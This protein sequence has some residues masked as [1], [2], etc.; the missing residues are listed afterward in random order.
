MYDYPS[1]RLFQNRGP[2]ESGRI[3]EIRD[4]RHDSPAAKGFG[5]GDPDLVFLVL[6]LSFATSNAN[7]HIGTL[8]GGIGG[9]GARVA[10]AADLAHRIRILARST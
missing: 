8:K 7:S 5:D 6:I 10:F 1:D 4:G 2:S 9:D 3:C